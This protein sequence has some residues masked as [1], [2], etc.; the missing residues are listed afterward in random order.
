MNGVNVFIFT[1]NTVPDLIQQ[2]LDKANLNL[3]DIDWFLLHQANRFILNH[4]VKRL[5]IPEDK[6]PIRLEGCGNTGS[7]SIPILIKD[8]QQDGIFKRG[9]RIMLIGF[10]VGY[11]WGAALLEWMGEA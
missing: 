10:G 3:D 8:L 5:R 9:D 7:S 4:L 6:A 2:T 1:I 11:S